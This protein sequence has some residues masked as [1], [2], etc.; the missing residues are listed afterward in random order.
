VSE[1]PYTLVRFLALRVP[2]LR[3]LARSLY[4]AHR[5]RQLIAEESLR[6]TSPI[7]TLESVIPGRRVN[8]LLPGVSDHQ[9]YGGGMTALAFLDAVASG[10]PKR[11]IVTDEVGPFE[12]SPE[13]FDG[14]ARRNLGDEDCVDDCL[15]ACADRGTG[16][17]PVRRDDVFIATA[18]WTADLAYR[19]V[20]WQ[21]SRYGAA[22]PIVYLIQ[23]YEPG[24]YPWSARYALAERTY[25]PEVPTIAVFN[26]SP[27]RDFFSGLGYQFAVDYT[28]EPRLNAVL[29]AELERTGI[30][31]RARQIVVYG[32]PSVPR[33]GFPLIVEALRLWS[34][35][36]PDAAKWC[37]L[38]VGEQHP[39]ITLPGGV[40]LRSLGKLDL[41]GYARLLA[42]SAVG[43]A[44][45]LSPHPSYPPLEMGAFG[46]RTISNRFAAK[47]LGKLHPNIFAPDDLSPASIAARLRELTVAFARHQGR[48]EEGP[49]SVA[50][51]PFADGGPMFPFT[52]E[53]REHWLHVTTG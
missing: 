11:L 43:I 2:S 17:L 32:R 51:T 36:A 46:M 22:C 31:D 5:A 30:P 6:E 14:W 19:L 26:S 45:M 13:R 7:Q 12:I 47:D 21:T 38:S 20:S 9:L 4:G 23:D 53:L 28:F 39:D 41:Q 40:V 25:H 42:E 34:A 52:D 44:L 15:V 18:W 8:L 35:A 29:A 16:T 48:D 50:G 33:N 49:W 27:L 1:G 37:V 24:F 10:I 3:R